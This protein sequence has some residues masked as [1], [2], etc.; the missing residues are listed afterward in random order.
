MTPSDRPVLYGYWRSSAAYRVRIALNLKGIDY[1]QSPVSLVADGG[2][3]RQPEHL[4]RNPQGL[5]PVL[6]IDGQN[7]VQ[8]LAIAEYLDET[9]PGPALL[10]PDAAGRARV[11]AL[12][13][14]VACEIHPVLNLR[15]LERLARQPGFDETAK[16]DWY[17]HF[18]AAGFAALER[19]LA[20]D[21][22]TGTYCHGDTPTLADA[23]LVPQ[24]YNARRFD[25]PLDAYPTIRRID[26]ACLTLPAFDL[27][28]PESQP[29]APRA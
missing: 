1:A 11:R 17:R 26:A 19:L 9:R 25:C 20:D 29:D 6:D 14:A 13:L 2:R 24:V 15:V 8:S 16:L 12:A 22:R 7:L 21:A 23:C 5:V 3:H 18:I 4:A 27:A 28:R 10:P